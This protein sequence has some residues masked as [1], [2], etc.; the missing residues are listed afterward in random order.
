MTLFENT[1]LITPHGLV[2]DGWLLT[3]GGQI[4]A[5]GRMDTR[6]LHFSGRVV[7]A[8]SLLLAPGLIDVQIN[9]LMGLDYTADPEGLWQSATYL[10]RYGVTTFLPTIISSPPEITHRALQV[11]QA[12]PPSG[13]MGA[14]P[15]GYHLEGPFLNLEKKGAHNPAH[16]RRLSLDEVA[17][18]SPANGVRLLTLAPELEGADQ[19]IRKVS[20]QGV[21]VSLGHSN[22]THAQAIQAFDLGACCG[23]HLF[24][25]MSGLEH[26][27]P[28]LAAALLAD[29]RAWFGLIADGVHV[30]P[31]IVAIAWA[32]A[33]DRFILV[34]D[35]MT[36]LGMP[37]GIYTLGD[38][39]IQ[40]DEKAAH[41]TN[42]TLAGS[43]L[44]LDQ[45]VRN[46]SAFTGCTLAEALP[47]A[48]HHPADLLGLHDR[49]KLLEGRRAD[50]AFFDLQGDV[51][52][53]FISGRCVYTTQLFSERFVS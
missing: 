14:E 52:A 7:D 21:I 49:G 4:A 44:S 28:G 16:L 11:L 1:A 48:T 3:D 36:A 17:D 41:L 10:P 25:A 27:A 45:A 23:T 6:P 32:A 26:R 38:Y 53:T 5:L 2:P 47:A 42:D 30:H 40:V 19:I 37:P 34:T 13:W 8:S 50:L 29:P 33:R 51:A 12:R 39:Q 20:Q 31:P 15:L 43:I 9:G 18:W 35:A 46:L 22:A 24:C